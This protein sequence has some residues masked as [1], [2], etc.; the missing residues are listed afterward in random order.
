[1]VAEGPLSEI[2]AFKAR[3][4]EL[5]VSGVSDAALAQ[6]RAHTEILRV[7]RACPMRYALDLPLTVPP[8]RL[9]AELA[10]T[11]AELVCR[12]IRSG[13]RSK[14]SSCGMWPRRPPT[15]ACSP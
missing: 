7:T 9:L 11:G 15:A 2:L 8:E 3:G 12:S 1:L 13:I 5:V 6:A 10:A 4:W 14:T